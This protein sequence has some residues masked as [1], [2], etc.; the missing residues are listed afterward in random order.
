MLLAHKTFAALGSSAVGE[1]LFDTPGTYSWIVPPG[2]RSISVVV[3]GGGGGGR[4]NMDAGGGGA[5]GYVNDVAVSSGQTITVRVGAGGA[6]GKGTLTYISDTVFTN[7]AIPAE[8]GE[9]SY[10]EV[11][12]SRVVEA[13]GGHRGD[14]GGGRGGTVRWHGSGGAGGDGASGV[15]A[16][17]GGAGGY[18]GDGGDG[19]GKSD[20]GFDGTGGAGG[21]GGGGCYTTGNND[22]VPDDVA[23]LRLGGGDGGG[24]GV[25]GAGASGAG[26]TGYP[27][28]LDSDPPS[29]GGN[30]GAGSSGSYG[31]GGGTGQY[32]FREPDADTTIIDE[33][34]GRDGGNGAVRIIYPG[35]QRQFP[36]TNAHFIEGS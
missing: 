10:I 18:A 30:G 27:D 13:R 9:S 12:G 7:P 35:D 24:V 32:V 15:S 14:A 16:G 23:I 17:G 4:N 25:F 34:E 20:D 21:G 26:G 22:Y 6:G 31:Y 28:P 8:S 5:L 29:R 11:P 36:S 33:G 1:E 2:V 19:G 3:V